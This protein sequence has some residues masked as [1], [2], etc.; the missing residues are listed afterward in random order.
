MA[1]CPHCGEPVILKGF[2]S[3]KKNEVRRE[4]YGILKK[5]TMYSCPH[6]ERVLGFGYFFGGL[7]TGRPR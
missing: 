4:V 3:E 5:E 6:C 7:I 1:K 2:D